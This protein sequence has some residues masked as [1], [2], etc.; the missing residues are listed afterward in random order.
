M[1]LDLYSISPT[2]T[3]C[4]SVFPVA[5]YVLKEGYQIFPDACSEYQLFLLINYQI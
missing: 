2:S 1:F 3:I 5:E 4:E